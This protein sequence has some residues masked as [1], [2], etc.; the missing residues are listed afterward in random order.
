MNAKLVRF[1]TSYEKQR[2]ISFAH[3]NS[4]EPIPVFSRDAFNLEYTCIKCGKIHCNEEDM[5]LWDDMIT[6]HTILGCC[7]GTSVSGCGNDVIV[8]GFMVKFIPQFIPQFI[9]LKRDTNRIPRYK[10][11]WGTIMNDISLLEIQKDILYPESIPDIDE[12]I[13]LEFSLQQI[14]NNKV[15]SIPKDINTPKPSFVL[16]WIDLLIY[17]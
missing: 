16:K 14:W 1:T 6:N 8:Q 7:L 13:P 4:L 11:L 12:Y 2:I 5:E 15:K 9:L 3:R 10:S 17:T